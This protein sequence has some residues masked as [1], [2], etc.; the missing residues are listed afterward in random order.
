MCNLWNGEST[1]TFLRKSTENV[2]IRNLLSR[3]CQYLPKLFLNGKRNFD[4]RKDRTKKETK[5]YIRQE[6]N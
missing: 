4:F 1:V 2:T 5:N 3:G 6:I